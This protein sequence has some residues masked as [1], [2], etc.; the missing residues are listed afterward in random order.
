MWIQ[1]LQHVG[2]VADHIGAADIKN[3]IGG[4]WRAQTEKD[5]I[6]PVASTRR[7][8]LRERIRRGDQ[9]I[10]SVDDKIHAALG[11]NVRTN[12]V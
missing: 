1:P 4:V 10:F 5:G 8:P 7:Q 3:C 6:N 11:A 9:L 12:S 2:G